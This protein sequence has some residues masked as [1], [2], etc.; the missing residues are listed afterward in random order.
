MT[1]TRGNI[2]DRCAATLGDSSTAFRTH[3]ETTVNNQLFD[4]WDRHDWEFKH[5]TSTFST[6]AGTE[7]Y[8]LSSGTADLRSSTDIEVMYDKTN[9]LFLLPVDLK[10]VR[11]AYPK[12]D[13][14]G[15]PTT[16]SPW[17]TKKVF[18][19]PE[20]DGIY[21]INFLYTSKPTLPTSDSHDMETQCG[22]PDYL[23]HV[24]DEM[25]LAKM[26]FYYDD[27]RY[28]ALRQEIEAVL[29]PNA[30]K[31]DMAHLESSARFKFWEESMQSSGMSYDDLLRARF[32][33][34]N[35]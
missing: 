6:V 20:P 22:L 30:I 31:A 14:S 1:M 3:A 12:E 27:S 9:G 17:G 29:L 15:K 11:K 23:H 4:L 2:I 13:T 10:D 34:N 8:T 21:V 7:S 33:N 19:N 24:I 5:K 18:L 26:L 25:V 16:Y 28:T 35:Y 32:Y